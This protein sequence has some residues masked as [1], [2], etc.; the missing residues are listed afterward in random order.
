MTKPSIAPIPAVCAVLIAAGL[1]AA[2]PP[3]R[4]ADDNA[5]YRA[6][7]EL[8]D[9]IQQATGAK[10]PAE[11][12]AKQD[13]CALLTAAEV[14]QVYPNARP[15]ERERGR[16]KYGITACLWSHPAGRLVVQ[17]TL[18]AAPGSSR[19]EAEGLVIGFVDPLKP[20]A[21]KTIR[22]ERIDGVGSE[23][24]AV[25][26]TADPNRGVLGNAAYL[27][28]QRGNVQL[29]V[30]APDLARGDRAAALKTLADLGRKAAGRL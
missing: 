29:L 12:I 22:V 18:G 19:E 24:A 23:A 13:P 11:P 16:E 5:T 21:G 10:P 8:A 30:S 20:G 1:L 28:T 25:V 17:L 26:E 2:Q 27:Y 14:R 6:A 15:A 4:A 7:R 3:A 9:K